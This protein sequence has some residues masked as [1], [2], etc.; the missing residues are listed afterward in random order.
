MGADRIAS[1]INFPRGGVADGLQNIAIGGMRGRIR[2]EPPPMPPKDNGKHEVALGFSY[3]NSVGKDGF[4]RQLFSFPVG[5][6]IVRERRWAAAANPDRLV[7]MIK[8]EKSFNRK[9]NGWE[10]LTVNGDASEILKREKDGKCLK[11]HAAMAANDFVF[12]VLK[13]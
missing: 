10:F 5:T 4:R 2:F 1:S 6:V 13:N 8:H 9:A 11:C 3:V 7:V 12:P